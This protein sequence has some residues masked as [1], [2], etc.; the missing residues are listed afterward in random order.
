MSRGESNA[1]LRYLAMQY[2]PALYPVHDKAA[3]YQID[4]ALEDRAETTTLTGK[5]EQGN[6]FGTQNAQSE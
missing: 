2:Q 6:T 3:C 5:Q 1:I 4:F